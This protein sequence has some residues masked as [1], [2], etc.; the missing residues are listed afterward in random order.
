MA[1]ENITSAPSGTFETG[2]GKLNIAANK[3]EQFEQL[4]EVLNR[5][6]LPVD[7]RFATRDEL[8]AHREQ[9]RAELEKSLARRSAVEWDQVLLPTGMP[10][11][12]VI[13]VPDALQLDPVQLRELVHTVPSPIPT[14]RTCACSAVRCM[15]MGDPA[16]PR[17]GRRGWGNAPTTSW[18]G[19]AMARRRPAV[20]ARTERCERTRGH[21]PPPR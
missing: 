14:G 15:S 13:S 10:A 9:L 5:P 11:A 6:D 7:E 21:A 1:N 16:V 4:C 19:W 18:L 20:C 8:K 2:D 17:G 12:P 3:Q